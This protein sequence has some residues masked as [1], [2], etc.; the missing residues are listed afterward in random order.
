MNAKTAMTTMTTT[1][2]A[3]QTQT[4]VGSVT[5][6]VAEGST[7]AVAV[8]D[9]VGVGE[10]VTVAPPTANSGSVGLFKVTVIVFA[11]VSTTVANSMKVLVS[12]IYL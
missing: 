1:A 2:T 4:G 12:G 10:V 8:A 7:D 3:A 5:A 11:T 6:G 9:D